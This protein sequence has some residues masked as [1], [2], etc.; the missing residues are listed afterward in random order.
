MKAGEAVIELLRQEGVT[1]IFGIV[2]SSCLDILDPLYDRDDLKFI[3]VRRVEPARDAR[4]PQP[5]SPGG[6]RDALHHHPRGRADRRQAVDRGRFGSSDLA[7]SHGLLECLGRRRLS[8]EDH[9]ELGLLRD[10]HGAVTAVD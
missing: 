4:R 8:I 3:G 1:H 7:L 6:L 9:R 2:G 10:E 5:R